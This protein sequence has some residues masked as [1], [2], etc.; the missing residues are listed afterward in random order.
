MNNMNKNM[1]TGSYTTE[2]RVIINDCQ[3]EVNKIKNDYNGTRV[4]ATRHL[5]SL[6]NVARRYKRGKATQERFDEAYYLL[7]NYL[8]KHKYRDYYDKSKKSNITIQ[9]YR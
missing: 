3:R 1:N 9:D 6:E 8:N 2:M 5:A 4:I 7:V